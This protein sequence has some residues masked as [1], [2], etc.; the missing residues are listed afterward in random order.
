PAKVVI[1]LGMFT[2]VAVTA[3]VIAN[4]VIAHARLQRG[5]GGEGEALIEQRL[6]RIEQAVDSIAVEV[7]RISE[8]QRFTTRLLSERAAERG[9]DRAL[10]RGGSAGVPS[11]PA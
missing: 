4:A 11:R 10:D 6:T 7:E 2:S 8:G 1:A 5:R 9:A 3:K